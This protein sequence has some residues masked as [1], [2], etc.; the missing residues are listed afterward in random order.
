MRA[1]YR[2]RQLVSALVLYGFRLLTTSG[3]R[4]PFSESDRADVA[5]RS[6][7]VFSG[8]SFRRCAARFRQILQIS[9]IRPYRRLVLR[10][11]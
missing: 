1:M 8:K 7:D 2:P 3:N 6:A 4:P 11:F 5:P 9:A 10:V